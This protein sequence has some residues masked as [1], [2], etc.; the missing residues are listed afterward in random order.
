MVLCGVEQFGAFVSQPSILVSSSCIT[1]PFNNVADAEVCRNLATDATSIL[2]NNPYIP[3]IVANTFLTILH[4]HRCYTIFCRRYMFSYF[5]CVRPLV[6]KDRLMAVLDLHMR[7]LFVLLESL[8]TPSANVSSN[9]YMVNQRNRLQLVKLIYWAWWLREERATGVSQIVAICEIQTRWPYCMICP[10]SVRISKEYYLDYTSQNV[11]KRSGFGT[12]SSVS[13]SSRRNF[14]CIN[15]SSRS[16]RPLLCFVS[17]T[18]VEFFDL[19][20]ICNLVTADENKIN[21]NS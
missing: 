6:D 17:L 18:S 4:F 12:S 5:L 2:A 19:S 16:N 9:P 14:G 15:V 20:E 11:S 10:E 13:V 7:S 21:L 3:T 1:A 8:N